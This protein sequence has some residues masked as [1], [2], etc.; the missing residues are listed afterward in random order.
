[1]TALGD[2]SP[3]DVLTAADLNAIGAW[4]TYTPTLYNMT[5]SSLN[6]SYAVVNDVVFVRVY[7]VV[8][9]MGSFPKFT[10]PT[11]ISRAPSFQRLGLLDAGN[12]W[13]DGVLVYSSSDQLSLTCMNTGGSYAYYAGITATVPHT[14]AAGDAIS[15]V[16]V[17]GKG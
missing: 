2:F 5:A 14:W 15:G 3:G 17:Y 9:T 8:A 1:M 16:F 13:F 4:Q 11:T 6:F 10:T 12:V 7:A